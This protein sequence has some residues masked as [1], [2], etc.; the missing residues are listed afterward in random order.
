MA[1]SIGP[2]KKQLSMGIGDDASVREVTYD[3]MVANYKEQI[4]ALVEAGV[5]ILLPET[6]FDTLV[7]KAAPV[8]PRFV[9]TQ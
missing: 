3:Q 2:T 9:R 4:A 1:G 7:M 5:D 8:T 6:A